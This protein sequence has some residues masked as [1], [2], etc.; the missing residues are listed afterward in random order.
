MSLRW[1]RGRA[2]TRSAAD[3][4]RG[5]ALVEFTFLAIVAILPLLYLVIGFSAVQRGT[6]AAAAGAREAGR[7][8]ALAD[9]PASG[10]ARAQ[11]AAEVA[12]QDQAVEPTDLRVAYAPAGAGCD[13][14]GS[15]QPTFAPGERF[16]VCVRVTIRVPGLPD[17]IDSNT[18]TGV[19]VVQR[20]RFEG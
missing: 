19:F 2:E 16:V 15:Y 6:F 13:A 14:A 1:R 17:F 3:P 7:A 8:L 18:A 12:V 5:A 20:D 9:D 10:L 4:D 11:Y